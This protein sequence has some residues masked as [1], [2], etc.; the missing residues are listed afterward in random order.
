MDDVHDNFHDSAQLEVMN[1]FL[2][3]NKSI[4]LGL[5]MSKI[6]N[7]SAIINKIAVGDQKGLFELGIHGW[8]HID[9]SRLSISNQTLS[10]LA[11]NKKMNL[12]FHHNSTIFIPPY[13]AFNNDT[14]TAMKAANLHILSSSTVQDKDTKGYFNST[15]PVRQPSEDTVYHMPQ[16]S[17][18]A[19]LDKK[20]IWVQLPLSNIITAIQGGVNEYGYAVVVLHPQNFLTV[21]GNKTTQKLDQNAIENLSRLVSVVAEKYQISTFEKVVT[22]VPELSIVHTSLG[23]R[24]YSITGLSNQVKLI[25]FV[26]EPNRFIKIYI[27]GQGKLQLIMPKSLIGK[28]VSFQGS[29]GQLISFT[30]TVLDNSTERVILEVPPESTSI[31]VNGTAVVPEFEQWEIIG[32]A[33]PSSF[34]LIQVFVMYRKHLLS[35]KNT[36]HL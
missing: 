18:F 14:V 21:E 27:E 26:I 33:L 16:V 3:Q 8:D 4:S 25:S 1:L 20:S 19:E 28:I 17:T 10:L 13:N 9:Y 12:L 11:A 35:D 23:A 34:I 24:T 22:S 36:S 29:S 2:T 32:L 7:D 31:Q 6:G 30:E 5:V 15:L